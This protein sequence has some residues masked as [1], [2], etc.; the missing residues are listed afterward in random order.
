V[1]SVVLAGI[2]RH[3]PQDGK[4]R[5][6]SHDFNELDLSSHLSPILRPNAAIGL[7]RNNV[8]DIPS[9]Q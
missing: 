2:G 7:R 1:V 4:D 6:F 3:P 8:L 9:H 5:R